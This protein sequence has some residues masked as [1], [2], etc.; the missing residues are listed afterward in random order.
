MQFIVF[1]YDIL[2]HAIVSALVYLNNLLC[3]LQHRDGE[4]ISIPMRMKMHE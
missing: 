4:K 1:L 2:L 3:P